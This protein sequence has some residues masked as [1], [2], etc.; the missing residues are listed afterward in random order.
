M[1]SGSGPDTNLT[2]KAA[3]DRTC[4]RCHGLDGAGEPRADKFFG[5]SIPRLNSADVQSKSDAELKE[6]ITTGR[7]GMAPV[8]IDEAGFRHRLPP[9][10]VDTLIAYVRTLKK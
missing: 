4:R 10:L 5:T 1:S 2:G 3:F 9:E 7:R 8:E 6:I